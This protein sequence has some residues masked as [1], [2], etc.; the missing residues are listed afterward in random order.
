M[1]PPFLFLTNKLL[2]M[3]TPIQF[4]TIIRTDRVRQNYGDLD[5]FAT[6][7]YEL[8]LIHP[9]CINH[10]NELIAG[11]RRCA[12]IELMLGN[13]TQFPPN[14][15]HISMV[16]LL[17]TG[18]L[19]YGV[20]YTLRPTDT[21]DEL[22][23]LELVENIQ[24]QNFSWQEQVLAV[25][26]VHQL[27]MRAFTLGQIPEAQIWGQKQT[28]RLLGIS[29]GNVNYCLKMAEH[30]TDPDSPI[31]KLSS[32]TEA[33]QFLTKQ[34]LDKASIALSEAVKLRAS[35][36]PSDQSMASDSPTT[37]AG[38]MTDFNPNAFS[39]GGDIGVDLSEF[40]PAPDNTKP[41]TSSIVELVKPAELQ[42]VDIVSKFIHNMKWEE[43][44]PKMGKGFLD[45]FISDPPFGIDM[46]MLAQGGGQGQK[47][48]DRIAHTHDKDQNKADFEVWLKCCYDAL[49]EK[50]FCIWFCDIEHFNYLVELGFK[51]GFKVQRWPFHWIKTTS[52]MNQRAEYN[53][54]KSVEHAIIFRKGDA[55]LVSAQ[56]NNWWM[57][58]NTVEDKAALP[59]H[60]F[61]KPLALWQHLLRAVA[62]PGSTVGDGF[63]GVGS[64]TR[65]AMLGGWQPLVCEMDTVHYSQQIH[66]IGEAYNQLRK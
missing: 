5:D 49:K 3:N 66:N 10:T 62:L 40:G 60:P 32:M 47:D 46:A 2:H 39:A 63:S 64:M 4:S 56:S 6:S 19:S 18:N 26:K 8:G 58:G 1:L 16:D 33:L 57:G 41:S 23:E 24:R 20:H 43:F 22:S 9:V 14:G 28:G 37:A 7:L 30:L 36:L 13:P 34:E 38:F 25:K 54:T 15:A 12:A 53:F 61:I 51:I 65:A 42:P 27:K 17:S 29:A 21:I 52:C 50:G 35:Q 48:I 45:H 44:Q 11:G 59:N 55:R 31:W